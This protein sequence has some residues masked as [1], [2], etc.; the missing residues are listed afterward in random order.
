MQLVAYACA[1]DEPTSGLA[2]V[3]VDSRHVDISGAGVDLTPE[4]NW[5]DAL[6]RWRAEVRRALNELQ[7]GDVRVNGTLSAKDLRPFGLLSRVQ[8]LTRAS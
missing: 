3:N 5:E 1:I 8:E 4:I 7:E 6:G 2:L